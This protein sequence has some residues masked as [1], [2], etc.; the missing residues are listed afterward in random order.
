MN[1][2]DVMHYGHQTV[3]ATLEGLAQEQL[4]MPGVS[5]RWSAKDVVAHLA[6]YESVLVDVLRGFVGEPG[7]TAFLDA[8]LADQAGF[9]E[10]QV[11][12]RAERSYSDVRA[13]YVQANAEAAR[14]MHLI[15]AS[16]RR[17]TGRLPWYGAEYD[18]EDFVAY[19]YYGH[20]REHCAQIAA[21]RD[22]VGST[23]SS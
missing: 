11:A 2:D 7:P 1:A 20:K 22:R 5:G 14:L 17:T 16:E 9:N 15:P 19:Q 12:D 3:L 10:T 6:S 18:L 21:F 8:F 13:E 23:H 4:T